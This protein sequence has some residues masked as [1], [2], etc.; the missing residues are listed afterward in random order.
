MEKNLIGLISIEDSIREETK[1]V[2]EKLR[3]LGIKNMVMLTGDSERVAKNITLLSGLD[4]YKANCF[5]EDKIEYVKNIKNSSNIVGMVGDGINDTPA[6]SASDVGIVM[7]NC[8]SDI[9][10]ETAD[11]I[12]SNDG[13]NGLID[14]R[15]LGNRLLN[16]IEFN[17]NSI[18][19][20]NSA[21][22]FASILGF[23]S[24]SSAAILHNVSTALISANAMRKLI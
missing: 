4:S 8:C 23:L 17:N 10:K 12:L 16:R 20:I 3:H 24:P 21:L 6:L 14:L 22:I 19:T 5:P 9:A 2:I 15:I 13:L 1:S 18:I 7:H 11:I